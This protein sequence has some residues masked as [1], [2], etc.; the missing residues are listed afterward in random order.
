MCRNQTRGCIVGGKYPISSNSIEYI[1]ISTQGNGA[2]FG[3]LTDIQSYRN[4]CA[5]AVRGLSLWL[6]PSNH[7]NMIEYEQWLRL[8]MQLILVI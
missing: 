1:T 8:E 5:N 7:T 4:A 6:N 2:D 3:D